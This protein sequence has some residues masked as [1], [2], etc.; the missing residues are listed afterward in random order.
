MVIEVGDSNLICLSSTLLAPIGVKVILGFFV[1]DFNFYSFLGE[2]VSFVICIFIVPFI[3]RDF[4]IAKEPGE[5]PLP[6]KAGF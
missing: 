3:V 2:A 1:I 4:L 6:Y 5:L